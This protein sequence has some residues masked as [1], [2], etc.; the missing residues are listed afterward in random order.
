MRL[1]TGSGCAASRDLCSYRAFD[2]KVLRFRKADVV[3][4]YKSICHTAAIQ[5][6][7]AVSDPYVT[8]RNSLC[9]K[10]SQGVG[11]NVLDDDFDMDR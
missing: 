9:A 2:L 5:K 7:D 8:L 11:M 3:L 6:C 4:R 10:C 1:A